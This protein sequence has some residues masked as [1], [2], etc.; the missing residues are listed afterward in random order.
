MRRSRRC[1]AALRTMFCCRDTCFDA[2]HASGR[3]RRHLRRR[4]ACNRGMR[5]RRHLHSRAMRVAACVV[6]VNVF[7]VCQRTSHANM[8]THVQGKAIEWRLVPM[9]F[10]YPCHAASARH[11]VARAGNRMQ[12]RCHGVNT[13]FHRYGDKRLPT[14]SMPWR[15][16][17]NALRLY[18]QAPCSVTTTTRVRIALCMAFPWHSVA[19][20]LP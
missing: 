5:S 4:G 11:H 16:Y 2:V 18:W 1:D 14:Y 7:L 12:A 9:R 10:S 15:S 20:V 6:A 17:G 19:M 3:S 8:T 13:Q